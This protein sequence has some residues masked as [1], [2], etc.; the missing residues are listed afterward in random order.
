MFNLILK[1]FYLVG[2][3]KI[4]FIFALTMGCLAAVITPDT[5]IAYPI[6]MLY[7]SN[8]VALWVTSIDAKNNTETVINSLPVS[9]P[10]VVIS[11]YIF[12]ALLSLLIGV[13]IYFLSSGL[14]IIK[15]VLNIEFIE[16]FSASIK[17]LSLG[18]PFVLLTFSFYYPVYFKLGVK[19]IQA[20]NT[21]FII[22]LVSLPTVVQ[23]YFMGSDLC[24]KLLY[25]LENYTINQINLFLSVIMILIYTLSMLLSLKLYNTRDL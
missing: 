14:I 17:V 1:D 2:S 23:R 6:V 25:I 12:T 19:S 5:F 3:V 11:K 21:L 22:L 15:D 24:N 10:N 7:L 4:M 20:T 13:L 8:V 18:F 16:G 9:K